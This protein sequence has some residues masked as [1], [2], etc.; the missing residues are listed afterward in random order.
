MKKTL[1]SLLLLCSFV[2]A[3]A[4]I[5]VEAYDEQQTNIRQMT[6]RLRVVN[7]TNETFNN[8]RLKYYMPYD[9]SR[10]L[11]VNPYYTPG[12]TVSQ[13]VV[14]DQIEINIDFPTLAPG[15][16]PNESG[17]SIGINYADWQSFDKTASVS[18]P[19]SNTYVVDDGIAIFIDGQPYN[20]VGPQPVNPAQPRFVGL[21]PENSTNR[22]AW[23]EI[24]NFDNTNNSLAGFTVSDGTHSIALSG[25]LPKGQKLIICKTNAVQCP[26]ADLTIVPADFNVGMEGELV[27]YNADN[28]PVDYLAWGKKGPNAATVKEANA[29]L[30][31]DEFL[32]T[33]SADFTFD[34]RVYN[35]SDFYRAVVSETNNTVKEWRLFYAKEFEKPIDWLPDPTLQSLSDGSIVTLFEGED[36]VFSWVAVK[37]A[38]KYI[39]TVIN[40]ATNEVAAQVTTAYTSVSVH[41]DP[42]VY[43]WTVE[44]S[45]TGDFVTSLE[46]LIANKDY[47]TELTIRT[48]VYSDEHIVYNLHVDPLA[49]R[50]DSY[51]LDLQWGRFFNDYRGGTPHNL[52]AY[53]DEFHQI[54]FS[55]PKEQHYDAEE[56]WR[57]WI[58]SAVMLNHYYG[59]NITQ[60]E[61]KIRVKNKYG[62]KILDA[63]PH[64]SR[65]G[66]T[67]A[68]SDEALMIALN[69]GEEDLN[70]IYERPEETVLNEALAQGRPIYIWQN[71]HIMTIDAVRLDP[72]LGLMEYRFINTDNNGTYQWLVYEKQA[73]IRGAWI[74]S[75]VTNAQNTDPTIVTDSDGDGLYD[76]DEI[77]RF[78]TDENKED[79]DDDKVFDRTEIVSYTLRQN[80]Y[81]EEYIAYEPLA[82]ADGD[83][84]R[85]E[86]DYD[87]DNGGANDGAEDKNHDGIVD[88]GETD[89]YVADDDIIDIPPQPDFELPGIY[90]ISTLVY[91]DNVNCTKQNGDYC[92]LASGG[93]SAN[94]HYPMIIG[95]NNHVGALHTP[96]TIYFQNNVTIH[97]NI[98]FYGDDAHVSQSSSTFWYLV[99]GEVVNHT[100]GEFNMNFPTTIAFFPFQNTTD[101][102]LDNNN[103][104]ATLENGAQ[105]RMIKVSAGTTLHI[106]AGEFWVNDIYLDEGG[107]IVFDAPSAH[108]TL[109]V[110]GNMIWRATMDH[111]AEQLTQIASNFEVLIHTNNRDYFVDRTFAGKIV[112][113]YSTVHVGQTTGTFYGSLIALNVEIFNFANIKVVPFAQTN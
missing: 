59:G 95:A 44:A 31:T 3:Q 20:I 58:V 97:G 69:I 77:N 75:N 100:L 113:P 80:N 8:V 22:S 13:E 112:A 36:M 18:Y 50:K 74:P 109:H 7:S 85:A 29:N 30:N 16:F 66:G 27:I 84:L 101:L 42:G 33:Y 10:T 6:L 68:N 103:R 104:T 87:S 79:S 55:D 56:S 53:Y 108:T 61:I 19:N 78:L 46:S 94:V 12:A 89:P 48:R 76:Y 35:T 62:D 52:S 25:D 9:A 91:R 11:Q 81:Y 73:N 111:N 41:L 47:L 51:L 40:D 71:Q 17:M 63:F 24:K 14:G 65:G 32:R 99:G 102:I 49:A 39:L 1:L 107:H 86:K 21:Q 106:P 60:D 45:Q 43:K 88:E 4:G 57:C 37:N 5:H 105:Y 96:S 93:I 28:E 82:D 15:M 110:D 70:F 38:K 90:G 92:D 64:G 34:E 2:F 54:Q 83:G 72:E 98:E 67:L 23:I 26:T